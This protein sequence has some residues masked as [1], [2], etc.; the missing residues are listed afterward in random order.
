MCIKRTGGGGVIQIIL[1]AAGA[2]GVVSLAETSVSVYQR[3]ESDVT[4]SSAWKQV[5]I[6]YHKRLL[7]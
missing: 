5:I 3:R 7:L 2:T 1:A 4:S 6:A